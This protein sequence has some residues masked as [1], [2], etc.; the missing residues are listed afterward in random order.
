MPQLLGQV[1]DWLPVKGTYFALGKIGYSSEL[2]PRQSIVAP[3]NSDAIDSV[4]KFITKQ[5]ENSW[6]TFSQVEETIDETYKEGMKPFL[7]SA[8]KPLS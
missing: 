3:P 1:H 2:P 4:F 8:L 6:E 7:E 5:Q